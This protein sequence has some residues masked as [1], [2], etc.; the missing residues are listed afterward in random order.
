MQ[1]LNIMNSKE[2]KNLFLLLQK[3]WGD[4]IKPN[5]FN[6]VF[7]IN[8]KGRIYISNKEVFEL[9]FSRLRVD[10]FGMYFGELLDK[11]IRLSIEGSQIIGPF[12]EKNV[13]E[14]D[15]KQVRD[16]LRGTDIEA[17]N[18]DGFVIL[19]HGKDFVGSGKFVNGKILN[20]VPKIRRVR[21]SD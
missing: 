7:L 15:D 19:K 2:K 14:L 6:Y 4:K 3:Q 10:S 18:L 5:K 1:K 16:W 8:E 17:E 20:F 12:A 13:A 21:S 9:D 11:T